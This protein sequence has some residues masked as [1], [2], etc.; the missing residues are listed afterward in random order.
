[1]SY[2][3]EVRSSPTT[4]RDD[5]SFLSEVTARTRRFKILGTMHLAMTQQ[6]QLV[7]IVSLPSTAVQVSAVYQYAFLLML[8]VLTLAKYVG[9]LGQAYL[10]VARNTTQGCL[11]GENKDQVLENSR[12]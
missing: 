5:C 4:G 2:E 1:M 7:Q 11:R 3:G 10:L 9:Q 6:C 8:S 12:F